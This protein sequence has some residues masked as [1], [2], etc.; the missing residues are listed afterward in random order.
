MA[1]KP[2][3]ENGLEN[4]TQGIYQGILGPSGTGTPVN[5]TLPSMLNVHYDLI[6]NNRIV[7]NQLYI[8][9][10]L[11]QTLV[12]QPI[13]DAFRAGLKITSKDLKNKIDDVN[14]YMERNDIW[15][16]IQQTLKWSRLFGGGGL[17][18]I[19]GE[20]PRVPLEIKKINDLTKLDFYAADLW[21]LNKS[22]TIYNVDLS[23][24]DPKYYASNINDFNKTPYLF[25][26]IPMH[27]SRILEAKGKE[28]PSLM[29]PRMRG[30]GMSVIERFLQSFNQYLK[31]QNV[32]YELLD[33]AKLDVFNLDQFK[34][35][36]LTDSGTN[37][38]QRRMQLTTYLKNFMNILVMDK[39]DKF[40][41]KQ[42]SF[43]GLG[44]ILTQVRQG[45]ASD[46]KMPITKL[47]GVSSAG[48]NSG[49]DD[50]ENYNSMIESEVRNKCKFIIL[51]V[52]E[53]VC[54]KVVGYVP[55]DLN[56]KWNPLR[57]LS[58]QQEEAIK[59]RSLN[60]VLMA[61]KAGAISIKEVKQCINQ[62]NLL[63]IIINET[64]EFFESLEQQANISDDSETPD[65]SIEEGR[66][67][68]Q[69]A[70]SL[71]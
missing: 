58:A 9:Q 51:K 65:K 13:D 70:Q 16:K 32:I 29:R 62:N 57:I 24:V 48:F 49:E 30:W 55:D 33:E 34:A 38:I 44:D 52:L 20:D 60:R 31:N 43:G 68:D 17:V 39:E 53:I 26:G 45:V 61:H 7:L 25:Y 14:L 67:L 8:C 4:L 35:S 10:G 42:I 11:V 63:P 18:I 71:R 19:T 21:E 5:S 46:M 66:D 22:W 37:D 47:F 6:F 36:L 69:A 2:N 27:E 40:E 28:A 12:D 50:I 23:E 54:Q 1:K 64:D 15:E 3:F 59:G 56:I 41:Q